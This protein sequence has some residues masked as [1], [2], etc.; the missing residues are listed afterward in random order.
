[1]AWGK[2]QP[3]I[4]YQRQNLNFFVYRIDNK[5]QKRVR[6]LALNQRVFSILSFDKQP[7]AMV[8]SIHRSYYQNGFIV[9]FENPTAAAIELDLSVLFPGM[10][11]IRVNA[12]EE[13]QPFSGL[14]PAYGVASYFVSEQ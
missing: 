10:T 2:E 6:P 3:T 4:S 14:I 11:P 13:V 7:D 12:V 8:S 9:R 1:M 5:I